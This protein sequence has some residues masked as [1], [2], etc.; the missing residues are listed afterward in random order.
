MDKEA[1]LL[2]AKQKLAKFQKKKQKVALDDQKKEEKFVKT[3]EIVPPSPE[4][5]ADELDIDYQI[6]DPG[7]QA[8]Q[9]YTEAEQ[10]YYDMYNQIAVQLQ[11][12][13]DAHFHTKNELIMLKQKF[14]E[15]MLN[16]DKLATESV[17]RQNLSEIEKERALLIEKEE[18]LK[19]E[20][21]RLSAL[22]KK[23]AFNLEKLEVREVEFEKRLEELS[24]RENNC[25]NIQQQNYEIRLKL[26]ERQEWFRLQEAELKSRQEQLSGEF[27]KYGQ[28]DGAE[29]VP[30]IHVYQSKVDALEEENAN[31]RHQLSNLANVQPSNSGG[32]EFEIL[33]RLANQESDSSQIIDRLVGIESSNQR[34]LSILQASSGNSSTEFC[35]AVTELSRFAN[36][37]TKN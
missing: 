24:I 14:D 9:H 3:S 7:V 21:S 2:A 18:R 4:I 6:T 5:A 8:E 15:N 1:K 25:K 10:Y 13:E 32:Y 29:P 22:E 17:N 20:S 12:S 35:K 19:M 27:S 34:I 36:Y 11:Q 37:F 26:E 16:K 28:D 30:D 23:I 31:L 33:Q